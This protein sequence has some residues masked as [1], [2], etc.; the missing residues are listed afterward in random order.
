M[1]LLRTDKDETLQQAISQSTENVS[2][3][4][5]IYIKQLPIHKEIIKVAEDQMPQLKL[6]INLHLYMK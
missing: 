2:L 3:F 6:K 4:T 1:Y 5:Q